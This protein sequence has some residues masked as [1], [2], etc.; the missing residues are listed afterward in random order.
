M[1]KQLFTLILLGFIT[2]TSGAAECVSSLSKSKEVMK[3][4]M[5][6]V[7]ENG[8]GLQLVEFGGYH[9]PNII[10]YDKS[11]ALSV[12]GS[13]CSKIAPPH[14]NVYRAI[15]SKIEQAVQSQSSMNDIQINELSDT[16]RACI[17][18]KNHEIRTAAVNGLKTLAATPKQQP[19]KSKKSGALM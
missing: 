10:V 15:S 16:L 2:S 8:Y 5:L 11:G 13:T 9:K 6:K 17:N 7:S 12:E 14:P 19:S 1:S 4:A 3:D 18:D